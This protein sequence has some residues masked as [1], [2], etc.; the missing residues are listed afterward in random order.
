MEKG[1]RFIDH[2]EELI[3]IASDGYRLISYTILTAAVSSLIASMDSLSIIN[4]A[5]CRVCQRKNHRTSKCPFIPDNHR[6]RF[7]KLK[8]SNYKAYVPYIHRNNDH[9]RRGRK[10]SKQKGCRGDSSQD[11]KASVTDQEGRAGANL[12]A[13]GEAKKKTRKGSRVGRLRRKYIRP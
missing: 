1:P 10:N 8:D 12:S 2:V 6:E 5:L 11:T 4:N 9:R 13:C 3:R 7:H